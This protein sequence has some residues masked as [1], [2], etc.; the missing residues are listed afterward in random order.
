MKA[1]I[2]VVL[3]PGLLDAQGKTVAHALQALGFTEVVDVRV[4]KHIELELANGSSKTAKQALERMC[5]KLLVNPV[6]ETYRVDVTR[7]AATRRT[8]R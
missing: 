4:G 2:T 5:R 8:T 7:A 1:Q 3:K 6:I